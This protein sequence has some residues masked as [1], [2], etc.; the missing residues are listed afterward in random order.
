MKN[1]DFLYQS[2]PNEI[3]KLMQYVFGYDNKHFFRF[4]LFQ[5][6]RVQDGIIIEAQYD[7]GFFNK[8]SW[9]FTYRDGIVIIVNNYMYNEEKGFHYLYGCEKD[10]MNL[11]FKLRESVRH[12]KV[13]IIE[14]NGDSHK[15]Y[16]AW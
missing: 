16:E 10:D 13:K 9:E 12:E 6:M 4:E 1:K 2:V 7:D 5:N 11:P 15:G 8:I 14:I 3:K